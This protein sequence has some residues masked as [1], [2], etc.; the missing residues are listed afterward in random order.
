MGRA[1]V[2]CGP[3][4]VVYGLG[5]FLMGTS[6]NCPKRM[7]RGRVHQSQAPCF[8]HD[9]RGGPGARPGRVPE[10]REGRLADTI[11]KWC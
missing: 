3:G 7:S 1:L 4:L 6:I 11:G 5:G 10:Y 2:V 8:P 9:P